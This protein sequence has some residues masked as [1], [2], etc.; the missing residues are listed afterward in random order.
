MWTSLCH[1]VLY[2]RMFRIC[3]EQ[4]VIQC[5][6][7][8]GDVEATFAQDADEVS[9]SA[10]ALAEELVN[11]ANGCK[12]WLCLSCGFLIRA[13][14]YQDSDVRSANES[15][16]GDVKASSGSVRRRRP[17]RK[18]AS[19]SGMLLPLRLGW[20]RPTIRSNSG[21]K[22]KWRAPVKSGK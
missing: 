12:R 3:R 13:S 20:R 2:R 1:K 8:R 5:R 14:G 19:V 9:A 11:V 15:A 21:L 4:T 7:E 17:F 6:R 22:R 18:I 16:G 10:E